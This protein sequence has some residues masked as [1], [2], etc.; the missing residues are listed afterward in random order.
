MDLK[1]YCFYVGG[2]KL[3][4]MEEPMPMYAYLIRHP[5]GLVLVDTGQSYPLRDENAVMEESDTI[6]PQLKKL[7]Y[8]PDDID[9]VVISHMHMDHVGYIDSFPNATFIVRKAELQAAWWPEIFE[10]GYDLRTYEH[11]RGF[12]FIQLGSDEDFD[13]FED[14]RIVLIDTRGH[15]RGHQSVVLDLPNTGKVV[16]AVDAAP[17]KEM[18]DRGFS[19]RP[20]TDSYQE[21][22]SLQK[23]RHLAD[24]GC[25][26]FYAHDPKNTHEKLAPEYYD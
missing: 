8:T 26:I 9:Y 10:R 11:T 22:R 4:F 25:R 16:L 23:I 24:C 7:G 20:N 13:V 6:L 14:G 19:D 1:L 3:P 17:D 5:K 21:A 2:I 12:R 15:S 18:L